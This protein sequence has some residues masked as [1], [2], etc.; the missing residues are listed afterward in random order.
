MSNAFK[1]RL[2]VALYFA[3]THLL[4]A[5]VLIVYIMWYFSF[6]SFVRFFSIF[7]FATLT[8][9]ENSCGACSIFYVCFRPH[10]WWCWCVSLSCMVSTSM[11]THWKSC[12]AHT[13]TH[14]STPYRQTDSL[15][16]VIIHNMWSEILKRARKRAKSIG[17]LIKDQSRV[18]VWFSVS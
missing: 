4:F 9:C 12:K 14:M 8:R 18:C 5:F 17:L 15:S 2:A 1:C 3:S 13:H 6:S 7:F 11:Y 10:C 16:V